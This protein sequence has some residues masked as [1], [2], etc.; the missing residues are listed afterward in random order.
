[1][2]KFFKKI[3]HPE[4]YLFIVTGHQG[5]PG[6]VLPRM[7]YQH[8]YH[9]RKEDHVIFSCSIIPVEANIRN[10]GRLDTELKRKKIRLFTDVHVSGHAF[11]ED[12]RDLIKM[13]KSKY[14]IPTHAD[15]K[16]LRAMKEL[17]IEIGYKPDKIKILKNGMQVSF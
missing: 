11:R 15:V 12:H 2:K 16:R 7:V 3:K 8:L 4:K 9:F 14:I 13:L 5:E 10:R 1:M 6:A 17:A